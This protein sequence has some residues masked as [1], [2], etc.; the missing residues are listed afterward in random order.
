MLPPRFVAD[1]MARL[2]AAT[3]DPEP[4]PGTELCVGGQ[5]AGGNLAAAAARL[6]M[7]HGGARI[8]LQVL[9]HA[10]LD[11]V[12]KTG[13]KSTPVGRAAVLRPWKCEVFETAYIPDPAQRRNRLASPAWG[14]NGDGRDGVDHG[15]NVLSAAPDAAD[16]TR[17]CVCPDRRPRRPRDRARAGVMA[18]YVLV[19]GAC[20][21]G[22]AF[23]RVVECL[24][25]LGHTAYAPT[26]AGHGKDVDKN[27]THAESVQSVLDFILDRELTDF[28]LL[29]HSYGGTIIAK[30][31]E[32]IPERVRRL[33]FFSGL[34]LNDGE[35]ILELFAPP[36]REAFAR[37]AAA[38]TDNTVTLPFDFFREMFINDADLETARRAYCR[39]SS[40]PFGQLQEPLDLKR[41]HTLEIPRSYLNPTEDT[42]M[43][44]GEWGWHPRLS[45]R[46]GTYRLVQM[47]GS[48]ELMFSNPVGLADK[49]LEAGQD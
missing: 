6:A 3:A 10:V 35:T 18:I 39:L 42:A 43:P 19:H 5:S 33:V 37:L 40:E 12:T 28:V 24:R 2:F 21:D 22:S 31:A 30:V 8:K 13:D 11:L 27:V 38:S 41:F 32:V 4:K 47:P 15:Y 48:Q 1:S 36:T 29:G 44:P 16:V 46:L 49:I 20:H 14:A 23:D 45:S 25:Q 9:H 17:P 7:E 26:V 34:V